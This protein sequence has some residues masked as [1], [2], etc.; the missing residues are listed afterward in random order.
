MTQLG[1]YIVSDVHGYIFPTDFSQANQQLP[2]GLLYANQLIEKSSKHDDIHFKIDN[3]DFLQ[4][5]PL[6]NYLV[7]EL[8]SS[9][10]LTAIY[11]RLNF[12]L[13]T[14]GNHE[15]N[16][17]L[18]Y[19]KDT[20]PN[21]NHPVLCANISD[22]KQHPFTGEGVHYFEKGDLT[23]GV[24][25]LTTQN[26][27]NWEQP[28]HIE[29]L[30]FKSAVETLTQVL[31]NVR[32]KADIVVVSYHG[33]FE[34]DIDTDEPTE[35]LTGENEAS[36]ILHRFHESIDV[37][38]TGHQH[39][40]IA[41]VKYDTAVIQP[42]TRATQVGKITLTI[43]DNNQIIHK[44]S[45]LI[46]IVADSE[47]NLSLDDTK[48]LTNLEDWLD[49]EITTLSE[50]M[51]VKDKF[52]ARITP[53][54]LVNLI[55]VMLL[56]KS[57]ADI[58]STA[59][60]DSA[61]GFNTRITMRDIINNYPFPNTFQVL[62]LTGASIKDALEKSASYFALNDTNEIIINDA[63]LYPKPQ[64]FNY[65]MYGGITYTIHVREPIGQRVT[66]I[67]VGSEPLNSDKTYTICVNNYRAVGGGNYNM[68]AEAPVVKDIQEEG[69]QLLI[70]FITNNDMSNIPQ[71]LNFKVEQ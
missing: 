68:F 5:A 51:L 65:D 64:H 62:K 21:L 11:N 13:G 44:Q 56:E 29:G 31:P 18:P 59:L 41:T 57:D 49:T 48:L 26:I 2:M 32:N 9:K 55:N 22:S 20:L 27:P 69:A 3:G 71:V 40:D 35:D 7:S 1:F 46:P 42:G 50:P 52:M 67:K 63:F 70:D 66:D 38:I 17:G 14:I 15:F 45:E 34:C 16:Y 61:A 30:T 12:D 39:R 10:P 54:P 43:D 19:L 47:F 37:L 24:I 33:G 58:A 36:E 6:C 23:V 28:H 53:H 8:R 25:G 4:G 60:F